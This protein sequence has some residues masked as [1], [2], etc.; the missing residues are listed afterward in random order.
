MHNVFVL[1][2]WI[3]KEKSFVYSTG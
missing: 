1:Q 2:N 3:E